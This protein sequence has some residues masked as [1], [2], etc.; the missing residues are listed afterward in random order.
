[1]K[2]ENWSIGKNG[3]TVI[4][5]TPDGLQENSGHSGTE[6]FDY[7]GGALVCESIWRKKDASLISA[8]PDLLE[9]CLIS[10]AIFHAQG[11][12]ADHA[13]MGKMYQKIEDAIAKAM[14]EANG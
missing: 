9:A 4:T 8:A 7:Y 13:I 6:A 10:R 2:K 12:T 1:M 11:I 5:D 14:G 3:G